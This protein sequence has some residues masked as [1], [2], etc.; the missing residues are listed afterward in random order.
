MRYDFIMP[1]SLV[2]F[3]AEEDANNPED[4]D[5]DNSEDEMES[6]EGRI[7]YYFISLVICMAKSCSGHLEAQLFSAN[8]GPSLKLDSPF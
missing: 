8:N 3:I 7:P 2:S 1:F 5:M 4:E 6:E